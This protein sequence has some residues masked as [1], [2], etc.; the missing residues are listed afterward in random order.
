MRKPY[1]SYI[2]ALLALSAIAL[3]S[4]NKR[5]NGIDNDDELQT[6]YS[7]YFSDSA[8]VLYN[9]ND[10]EVVK[11]LVFPAD[12]YPSRAFAVTGP[13][14]MVWIKR[15]AHV[16]MDGGN[17]FGPTYFFVSPAAYNQSALLYARD[18]ERVY[19]AST[20]ARGVAYN[21]KNG[22]PTA[23]QVDNSWDDTITNPV[24]VTSYA[25]FSNGAIFGYDAINYRLFK[26]DNKDDK[27]SAIPVDTNNFKPWGGSFSLAAYKNVLVAIDSTDSLGV[28]FSNNDGVS[29]SQFS[30][31]PDTK[32]ACAGAPFNEELFVGTYYQGLY[33]LEGGTMVPANEGL[34]SN[35]IVRGIKGKLER[36]KNNSEKRVVYI[37]TN[38]GVY[39]SL[40]IGRNWTKI[41]E[42][43]FINVY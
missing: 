43:N 21:E 29:W 32:I 17:I 19:I 15:N 27:W 34:E 26:K 9:T 6:P 38:K 35:L 39:R 2:L 8:G 3:D 5:F 42:G 18:Q 22:D 31:L 4:C 13:T 1:I 37:T 14:H 25:Q 36:Y 23:W 11:K 28:W 30:G 16:S 24:S 41:K 20:E 7:V 12:G 40:D 33:R 10:G